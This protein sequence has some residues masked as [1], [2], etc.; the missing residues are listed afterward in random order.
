MAKNKCAIITGAGVGIGKGIAIKLA[1]EGYNV[2]IADINIANAKKTASEIGKS[3][4]KAMAVQCDV[5]NEKSV[6]EMF[7][8]AKKKFGQINVLV[9]NAGIFP[10]TPFVKISEE[11]W[12]KVIDVNLK[13]IF[14]CSREAAKS[15]GT[16]GRIINISSIA[17]FV[18]FEGLT[19]Y[20]ASKSGMNGL[21][22]A[23]ALELAPKKITVNVVAPGAIATPGASKGSTKES[24]KQTISI[25]PLSR[26]GKPEDIANATAF[27]ASNEASYITGQALIVD[28]GYTLR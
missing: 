25:I 9:N 27:L 12:D 7:L 26:M 22:R 15:M 20:C 23:L 24:I 3:G 19:H 5:S 13:S 8:E 21:T 6:K 28:G 10:F 1:R 11:D 16:G 17:A 4:K 18:G 2:V 14:L